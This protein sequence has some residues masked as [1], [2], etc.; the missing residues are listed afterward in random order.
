MSVSIPPH[1]RHKWGQNFLKDQNI[2]LKL[3]AFCE[4]SPSDIVVEIGAGTGALTELLA[5]SVERLIAVEVDESLLPYLHK[6]PGVEVVHAD[7]R[8]TDVCTFAREKSIRVISNLPYYISTAILTSLIARRGCIV[9][10]VLMFQEEV[11]QR[12]LASPATP[13]YSMLSVVAQYFCKIEKGFKISRN[14]FAPKPEIDSRVLRFL[15]KKNTAIPYQTFAD[16]VAK[17]FSQ[18]RKKLRNNLMRALEVSPSQIDEA[19]AKL[20]I[21]P[22]ARAENLTPDQYEELILALRH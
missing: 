1:P 19:F 8:R 16:F 6:I 4:P 10:M 5:P 18:R 15:P 17:A 2:L 9:D 7:I 3:A 11:G 22:G 21:E 13:N 12:I 14:S 20:N